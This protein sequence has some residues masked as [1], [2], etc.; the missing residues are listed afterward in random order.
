[1]RRSRVFKTC[2]LLYKLREVRG[3]WDFAR[4]SHS[5]GHASVTFSGSMC[6][7]HLR[8]HGHPTVGAMSASASY[9]KVFFT[10][11]AA[12]AHISIR[13]NGGAARQDVLVLMQAVWMSAE[14]VCPGRV[15]L[16]FLRLRSI[17]SVKDSLT[18]ARASCDKRLGIT[19]SNR[20]LPNRW[21]CTARSQGIYRS[22]RNDESSGGR[23]RA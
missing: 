2:T 12:T 11:N 18:G 8:L 1:M 4:T 21:T 6:S 15:L 10:P 13:R 19:S 22:G 9:N 17:T 5:L 16:A 3:F 14:G 7:I 20:H 23:A